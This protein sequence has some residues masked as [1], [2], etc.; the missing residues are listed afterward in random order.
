MHN[1]H[2]LFIKM[3]HRWSEK[4]ITQ[5]EEWINIRTHNDT[6]PLQIVLWLTWLKVYTNMMKWEKKMK[7]NCCVLKWWIA[8]KC[9]CAIN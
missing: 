5:N 6:K 8:C 9:N 7:G 1:S 3:H 4:K 2:N